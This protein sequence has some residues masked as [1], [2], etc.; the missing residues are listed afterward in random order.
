MCIRDSF[1]P[2][3]VRA[4]WREVKSKKTLRSHPWLLEELKVIAKNGHIVAQKLTAIDL[5]LEGSFL[6]KWPHLFRIWKLG[7]KERKTDQDPH[8]SNELTWF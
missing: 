5:F 4:G 1:P 3:V 7:R 2:A 8:V 6:R